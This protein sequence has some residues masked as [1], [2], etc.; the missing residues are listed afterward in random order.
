MAGKSESPDEIPPAVVWDDSGV[1]STYANASDVSASRE[2]INVLF[3]VEQVGDLSRNEV[4]VQLARR[5]A[6]SPL[7][8]KR[9][10][11]DLR[12]VLDSHETTQ[13]VQASESAIASGEMDMTPNSGK[14]S[15]DADRGL[16][17][18][19]TLFRQVG[20]LNT[21]MD[22][23]SS[24]KTVHGRIFENRFLLGLDRRE[25]K[26]GTDERIAAI[27]EKIGM[28]E[29]LLAVFSRGLPDAN[30]VYF[31]VEKD[32]KTLMFKVYLECR[33]KIEKQIGG[34]AVAG[35][36]FPLFTGY[37]WDTRSP[38]RQAVTR[39][40][41]Y[42]SLPIPEI[43][44]RLRAN[45]DSDGHSALF[46][47]ARGIVERASERIAHGDIQYLEVSEEG[48]P[49]KSFDLNI[50]KSGL[51]LVDLFP[52]LLAALQHYAIPAD[53]FEHLYQRIKTERF[54][55]LAGGID[56]DGN[57]FMTVYY[58]VNQVHSSQFGTATIG[59]PDGSQR[60]G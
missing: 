48:N 53:R 29:K 18:I 3:G 42:P 2:S 56:R 5:F 59:A 60:T 54:G 1:S 23:E 58:G 46:E 45:V 17:K 44:G 9:F 14:E 34:A 40:D 12:K 55:H 31:G 30:H 15:S 24:F 11:I 13:G 10:A 4:R 41:W 16:E 32:E 36:S 19:L 38:E 22:L 33:D 35:Q 51:R 8:A 47:I 43:L 27:C 52:Q 39:Y 28:P 21:Q 49:R 50:Y 37:K 20:G 26:A 57:D 25:L 7:V 6:M